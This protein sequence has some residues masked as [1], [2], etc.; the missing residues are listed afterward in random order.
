MFD[1]CLITNKAGA[2]CKITKITFKPISRT[3]FDIFLQEKVSNHP[4]KVN[5]TQIL[6]LKAKKK[7]SQHN[8]TPASDAMGKKKKT[9]KQMIEQAMEHLIWPHRAESGLG[10]AGD[11]TWIKMFCLYNGTKRLF[12]TSP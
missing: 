10:P 5:A 4:R 7:L 12:V 1:F 6:S 9:F 8:P 2:L 11:N 3:Y